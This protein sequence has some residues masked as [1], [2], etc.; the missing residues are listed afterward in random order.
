MSKTVIEKEKLKFIVQ[1]SYKELRKKDKTGSTKQATV[2][3]IVKMIE[4][5]LKDDN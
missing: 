3:E 5:V 2:N 1:G 4:R